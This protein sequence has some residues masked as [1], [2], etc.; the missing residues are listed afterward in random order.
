MVRRGGKIKRKYRLAS[1]FYFRERLNIPFCY[2]V[3]QRSNVDHFVNGIRVVS[4]AQTWLDWLI[5]FPLN[6]YG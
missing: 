5:T 2:Q 1:L 4:R 6:R 3:V